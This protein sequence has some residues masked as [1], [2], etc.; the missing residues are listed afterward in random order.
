MPATGRFYRQYETEAGNYPYVN[1]FLNF[2]LQRTRIFLM[3][4]HI[5]YGI[6]STRKQILLHGAWLSHEY[7]DVPF[8]VCL[9]IL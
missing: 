8:W 7:H 6:I 5:N 3:F 4:D 9:D 1:L 2:K